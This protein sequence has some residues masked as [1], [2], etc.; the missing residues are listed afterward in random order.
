[1]YSACLSTFYLSTYPTIHLPTNLAPYLPNY[2]ITDIVKLLF[3][4]I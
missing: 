4:H 2:L 1:M 3:I